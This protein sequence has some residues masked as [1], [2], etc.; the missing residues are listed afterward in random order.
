[1]DMDWGNFAQ[2]ASAIVAVTALLISLFNASRADMKKALKDI[3]Q[4]VDHLKS[5]MQSVED[6]IKHL[7]D[8]GATH[9]L[10][11]TMIELQ[12]QL[13]VMGEKLGPVA[14]IADRLQEF[15]IDQARHPR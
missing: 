10:E 8:T 1:M 11:K 14:K 6:H 7:P 9:R 15:L 3:D 4:D 5:R 2:L 13:S 12:G